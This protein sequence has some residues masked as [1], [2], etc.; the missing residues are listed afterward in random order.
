VRSLYHRDWDHQLG[1][2]SERRDQGAGRWPRSPYQGLQL[3]AGGRQY[4]R[5][6]QGGISYGATDELRYAAVEHAV[7]VPDLHATMC[8]SWVSTTSA[9]GGQSWLQA[10]ALKRAPAGRIAYPTSS[11]PRSKTAQLFLDRRLVPELCVSFGIEAA[12]A[13]ADL[14]ADLLD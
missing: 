13:P 6:H 14:D 10:G 4:Q 7:A 5:R 3:P 2:E 11:Q 12:P 8:T 9:W 1:R